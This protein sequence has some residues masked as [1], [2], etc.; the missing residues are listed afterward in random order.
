MLLLSNNLWRSQSQQWLR[1]THVHKWHASD[2]DS[3]DAGSNDQLQCPKI[4]QWRKGKQVEE[5]NEEETEATEPE[6]V[7]ESD[8]K[9][10][11]KGTHYYRFSNNSPK[12]G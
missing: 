8:D 12:I 7:I 1:K 11:S 2:D 9:N 10:I 6:E 5:V 4:K 3:D